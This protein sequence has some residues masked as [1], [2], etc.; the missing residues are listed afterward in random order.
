MFTH[1]GYL[2]ISFLKL[3]ER[4]KV[5][6]SFFLLTFN[7]LW[8]YRLEISDAPVIDASLLS[9]TQLIVVLTL[10]IRLCSDAIMFVATKRKE[11][12]ISSFAV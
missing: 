3:L 7:P 9:S 8:N 2:K 5:T 10:V 12:I 6:Q 11:L 1:E 4:T